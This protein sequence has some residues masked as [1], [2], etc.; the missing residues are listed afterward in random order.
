MIPTAERFPIMIGGPMLRP[1]KCAD[2][3]RTVI[4]AVEAWLEVN[5]KGKAMT[6]AVAK[7]MPGAAP[8]RDNNAH[9]RL[10]PSSPV[11][12]HDLGIGGMQMRIFK[13]LVV[14]ASIVLATGTQPSVAEDAATC[15][16]L[17]KSLEVVKATHTLI[18]YPT[19]SQRLGEQGSVKVAVSIGTDGIPTDAS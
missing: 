19:I 18:P 9:V 8:R 17:G 7:N 10:A 6:A 1:D 13:H 15:P 14:I 11:S 3:R 16:T 12:S 2:P 4:V 5:P